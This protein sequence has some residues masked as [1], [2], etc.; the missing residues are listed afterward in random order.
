MQREP[1]LF[2]AS[3]LSTLRDDLRAAGLDS[4]QAAELIGAFLSQRGYGVSNLDARCAAA[5]IESLG[6]RIDCMRQEL[7]QLALVM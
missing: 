7:K 5:R 2:A 4:W 1:E 6:C 3:D